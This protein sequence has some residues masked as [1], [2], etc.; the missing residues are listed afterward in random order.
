MNET[1]SIKFS[2]KQVKQL[3]LDYYKK[4][5][6]DE[7]I[8]INYFVREEDEQSYGTVIIT[9]TRNLKMGKY[10][11]M[12]K[13]VLSNEDIIQVINEELKE[14][15]YKSMYKNDFYEIDGK[16]WNG[17]NIILEKIDVHKKVFRNE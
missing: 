12:S 15:G 17:I 1:K 10:E 14:Y 7:N 4:Y 16:N 11:V 8:N 3:L 6:K 5:F 2:E 13:N 9:I